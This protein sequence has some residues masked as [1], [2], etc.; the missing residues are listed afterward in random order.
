[1]KFSPLTPT[2]ETLVLFGRA[3]AVGLVGGVLANLIGLPLPWMLGPL[4]VG[5]VVSMAGMKYRIPNPLKVGAR[6]VIGV[7]LGAAITPEVFARVGQWPLSLTILI[8]GMIGI[9]VLVALYYRL[10]AR[11]DPVTA[12]ASAL[13]GGLSNVTVIALQLGAEPRQVVIAQLLRISLVVILVPP[14]YMVWQGA[15]M[16][17][18]WSGPQTSWLGDGIWVLLL[19][20]PA[21]YLGRAI[22]LPMPELLAPMCV[23]AALSLSAVQITLPP[24]LFACTFLVL[25]T[26]IGG[27]FHGIGSPRELLAPGGHAVVATA[28]ILGLAT[29]LA[30]IIHW[31]TGVPFYVALLAVT[32]GGIAEMAILAAAL[33]VDPLFVIFHQTVRSVLL[34]SLSPIILHHIGKRTGI[35]SPEE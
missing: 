25:G 23:T 19:A 11:F 8:V 34:N 17:G 12:V 18:G 33:G 22:R 27:R 14:L 32:P 13:P 9:V 31:A 35:R 5:A 28:L 24:W 7:L 21:W 3:V 1:M 29:G 6:G 15:G 20:P 26:A 30:L 16:D 10:V 4:L 2:R